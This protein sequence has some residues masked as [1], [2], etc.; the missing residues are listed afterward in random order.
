ML[1]KIF[2]VILSVLGLTFRRI[3]GTRINFSPLTLISLKTVIKTKDKN[4]R[5][6][7]GYR[8]AIRA[9]TEVSANGGKIQIGQR[10]FINRNCLIASHAMIEIKDGVTIGPGVYI[11]DHDHDGVGGYICEGITIEEDVWIG[12]SCVILKGVTIG[13]GSVIAAGTVVTRDIPR[14]SIAYQKKLTIVREKTR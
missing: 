9:N 1:K 13:R 11:Y 5:I 14:N 4:S 8:S 10:C 6:S 12:A 2:K 7:I 3:F